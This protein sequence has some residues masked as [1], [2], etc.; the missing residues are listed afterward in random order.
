MSLR[1]P[2][3]AARLLVIA[4]ALFCMLA[5]P[6]APAGAVA[7][8]YSV[9]SVLDGSDANTADGICATAIGNCT[10]RAAIQQANANPGID[11]IRNV[12][13]GAPG[14]AV[15]QPQP[16]LPTITAPVTIDL[17]NLNRPIFLDG[18][19]LGANS[20][21]IT[22]DAGQTTIIGFA[23][24]NFSRRGIWLRTAGANTVR[25]MMIGTNEL[26]TVAAPNNVGIFVDDIPDNTIGSPIG[27]PELGNVISG[28]TAA[29]I[30]IVGANALD[31]VAIANRI[32]VN[33]AGTAALPNGA[34]GIVVRDTVNTVIYGNTISGNG[35]DGLLLDGGSSAEVF[36]NTIGLDDTASADLG[37][38]GAGVHVTAGNDHQIGNAGTTGYNIISGNGLHGIFI[39]DAPASSHDVLHNIIGPAINGTTPIPNGGAGVRVELSSDVRIGGTDSGPQIN[40]NKIRFN[41]SSGIFIAA[42]G[43][44]TIGNA[45]SGNTGDGVRIFAGTGNHLTQNRIENNSELGIDLG[46][47]GVTPPD[48]LG[49]PDAGANNLQNQPVLTGAT[50][51]AASVTVTGTLQTTANV[52]LQVEFFLSTTCDASGSGEGSSY[53]GSVSP[54]AD[55][56]G[57]ATLN[58]VQP[59][60]LPAGQV[61]T[62]VANATILDDSS[63]F[64]NCVTIV[65]GGDT[66]GDGVL[67]PADNCPSTANPTQTNTD[68]G[69]TA[70]N[71]PGTDTLGDACDDDVDGDGYTDAQETALLPAENPLLYCNIMRAD[72][73]GD[74]VVSILDLTLAAARFTQSIPPSPARLNQDSDT[75]ISILD[76]TRMG[77]VFTQAV[78]ACA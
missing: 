76:L 55:G 68:S 19:L 27:D 23:I 17:H 7:Q 64:S 43:V 73:D 5:N 21:G 3:A 30:R 37:N 49:D 32:G 48:G 56:T 44:R 2:S 40:S 50:L 35:S 78:S 18:S 77:N 47:N 36:G 31:N 41:G 65:A 62:A 22:V 51:G 45:I 29:G 9:D 72:V 39:E 61:I 69:N 59:Q 54:T 42:D 70:A 60:V 67:D 11:T 12:I 16:S 58:F 75:V 66:D 25:G 6:A 28:N 20:D 1:L 14:V 4:A 71:R 33:A 46:T 74:H 53:L 63:E 10:L 24:G 26:G 38:A 52:L 57:L 34:E 8:T 15:I 13:G